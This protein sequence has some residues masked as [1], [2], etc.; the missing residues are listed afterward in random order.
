MEAK[1][2]PRRIGWW[3]MGLVDEILERDAGQILGE[4]DIPGLEHHGIKGQKWGMR[5]ADPSGGGTGAKAAG[6]RWGV[7][8]ED[9]QNV[10]EDS[11]YGIKIR[12]NLDPNSS[13]ARVLWDN[14]SQRVAWDD[15]GVAV[16]RKTLPEFKATQAAEKNW[17]K[18]NKG[19]NSD[20]AF[21]KTFDDEM[22]SK[23]SDLN[24]QSKY[25]DLSNKFT[26]VS[27]A[28][29]YINGVLPT[30]KS[31]NDLTSTDLGKQYYDDYQNHA[32]DAAK[33]AVATNNT[34]SPTGRQVVVDNFDTKTNMVTTKIIDKNGN[35]ASNTN[36]YVNDLADNYVNTQM[37]KGDS[38][39]PTLLKVVHGVL[40]PEI[41]DSVLFYND[42]GPNFVKNVLAHHGIKGM[43]WG[44]ITRG[45]GSDSGSSAKEPKPVTV[46]TSSRL[47]KSYI[48]TDGG[49]HQ[50]ASD[51][52]V[53]AQI[54]RQKMK[55]S[56]M[57]SLSN[58]ELQDMATRIQLEQQV[59]KLQT[60][61]KN[62]AV[63]FVE[64]NVKQVANQE[65]QNLGKKAIE[66]G[67]KFALDQMMNAAE[68]R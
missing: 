59:S 10:K 28:Q 1:R 60:S 57:N 33:T 54:A 22:G 58:K 27:D 37:G 21:N 45:R 50:P 34:V 25:S 14:P 36:N 23:L 4:N 35:E 65:V 52:A 46:K 51:D 62:V 31:I 13:Q 29:P 24:S 67:G 18:E 41:E 2:A 39:A 61:N 55:K 56:G 44:V 53:K 11:K 9:A 15:E 32:L 26:E 40:H 19:Y 5:R 12:K 3:V 17:S 63:K 42:S 8:V 66:N 38:N 6:G 43:K 20:V 64:N 48:R 49:S 47:G 7:H 16:R 68:K 30:S